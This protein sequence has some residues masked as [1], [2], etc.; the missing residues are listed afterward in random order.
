MAIIFPADPGAQSPTNIFGPNSSP[1]ATSNGAEYLWDGEKW[2]SVGGDSGGGGEVQYL[3]YT[4]PDGV[5][6][7]VQE[8]LEQYVSIKDF[9]AV[10]DGVTDDTAAIQTAFNWWSGAKRR[11]LTFPEGLYICKSQINAVQNMTQVLTGNSLVGLGGRLRFEY[12]SVGVNTSRFGLVL[13][14]ETQ[15]K[16]MRELH[17]SGL[18]IEGNFDEYAMLIDGGYSTS[19]AYLYGFVIERL[20]TSSRGLCVSGNAFEGVITECYIAGEQGDGNNPDKDYVPTVPSLL[21]TQADVIGGGGGTGGGSRKISSMT[22]D[23]NNIRGGKYGIQITDGASDVTLRN[24]TTLTSW[25]N[26]LFYNSTFSG[27]NIL[28]HHAEN[29]WQRYSDST[30]GDPTGRGFFDQAGDRWSGTAGDGSGAG[31]VADPIKGT[32]DDW[33]NGASSSDRNS[34]LERSGV[35]V[36]ESAGAG[37]ILGCRQVGDANGGTMSAIRMFTSTNQPTLISGTNAT[38]MGTEVCVLGTGSVFL[39]TDS[40]TITGNWPQIIQT[41]GATT[42]PMLQSVVHGTGNNKNNEYTPFSPSSQSSLQ[43]SVFVPLK[44]GL[45]VNAPASNYTPNYGDEFHMTFQ[46]TSTTA[47]VV[48]FNA[49]FETNGFV[50]KTGTKALS[51]ISFKYIRDNDGNDKWMITSSIPATT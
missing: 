35:S 20:Y 12:D 38:K 47:A 9:G 19:N 26:G 43:G 16:L 45:T 41:I 11:A 42:R 36:V 37:N 28:H 8:R 33:Y 7:T 49:I 14:L 21:I 44:G 39:N 6:Q 4:Y 23:S 29:C 50:A 5:E 15:G 46:Q 25:Q 2:V 27:C 48:T 34:V 30:W 51:T 13:N 18:A 10:G 1:E 32:W 40:Y 31:T 24:N 3:D 22:L 17:I